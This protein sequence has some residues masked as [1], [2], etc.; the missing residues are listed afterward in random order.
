MLE[1]HFCQV[2]LC[3]EVVLL[4][5][6]RLEVGYR[7]AVVGWRR[8]SWE[9]F[10]DSNREDRALFGFALAFLR[11]GLLCRAFL[12]LEELAITA[13]VRRSLTALGIG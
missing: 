13:G 1:T 3:D 9:D 8:G 2:G 7:W 10:T 12:L 5:G 4:S 11:R 6:R